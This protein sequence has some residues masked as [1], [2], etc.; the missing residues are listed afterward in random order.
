METFFV[1]IIVLS[2]TPL[3][4]AIYEN[5]ESSNGLECADFVWRT[6]DFFIDLPFQGKI[7][8]KAQG[9]SITPKT[10]IA[11]LEKQENSPPKLKPVNFVIQR[12][13]DL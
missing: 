10:L 2:F 9:S 4:T 5:S 8:Y 7:L 3:L 11:Y 12:Y 1:F 6:S 13:T